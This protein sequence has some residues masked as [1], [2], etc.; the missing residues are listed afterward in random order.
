MSLRIVSLV[1]SWTETLV[2]AGVNVVGRTR[3]CIHPQPA[4][5]NIP[6]VAG[7]KD[8][9]WTAI[10]ALNPDLL[11]LDQEE[12]PKFMSEQNTIAWHAT[13][14][15]GVADMPVALRQL[16]TLLKNDP[17]SSFAERWETVL[18]KRKPAPL[19]NFSDI[20]GVLV[21]GK[22]P[23]NHI[24][25]VLYMIWKNPWIAVSAHTFI[26]SLLHT[27]GITTPT[28]AD[29][30]PKI[31]MEEYSPE[32]TLLL[33]SSEPYP[34]FKK[35]REITNSISYPHAFVDGECFSWFGLRSLKFLEQRL[36]ST[37]FHR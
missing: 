14:I 29:K 34:F 25:T 37:G 3:F 18:L 17:L 23:S 16:S 36:S 15:Q 21:W 22:Q 1:P 20:P 26:G 32:D 28:F 9:D 12:N 8:W 4:I 33:F 10:T 7:T 27:V 30:Y 31:Q 2:E 24:K 35:K 13:H 6:A 5:K 19:Q 11:L